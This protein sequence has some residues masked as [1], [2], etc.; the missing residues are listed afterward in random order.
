[1]L[2]KL[3]SSMILIISNNLENSELL[4]LYASNMILN[5]DIKKL[6][7]E[8]KVKFLNKLFN[9]F[10]FDT[11]KK[12]RF[13]IYRQYNNHYE[14]YR[15]ILMDYIPELFNFIKINNVTRLDFSCNTG[16]LLYCVLHY[17]KE[18]INR[19]MDQL[20]QLIESNLSHTLTY[21]NLGGFEYHI[22]KDKLLETIE[23][24]PSIEIISIRSNGS[25]T[26]FNKP[27]TNLYKRNGTIEWSHF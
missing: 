18:Q 24:H 13:T 8:R 17:S 2:T 6:L 7:E 12:L 10:L 5:H 16:D 22:D 19:F 21:C 11:G 14:K 1:M 3:S 20:Y 26:D 15:N 23:N 4:E 9:Y 25:R 27:P